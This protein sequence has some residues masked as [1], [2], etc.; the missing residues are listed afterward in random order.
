MSSGCT[1]IYLACQE[2]HA[3]VVRYLAEEAGAVLRILTYDGMSCLHT[4]AQH[5]HNDIVD[6]LVS[7]NIKYL[8][9]NNVKI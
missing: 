3:E 1:A 8:V 6:Y 9:N 2:G 4:A 5:G 7:N